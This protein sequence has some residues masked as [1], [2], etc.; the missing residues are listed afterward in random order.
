MNIPPGRPVRWAPLG[1]GFLCL[2][3]FGVYLATALRT[4]VAVGLW[5]DDAIY[6]ATARS[7]AEGD[8]YRHIQMPSRP[9]QTRYPMLYPAMLSLAFL[10]NPEYP[11]NLPLL[12]APGAVAAAGLLLLS[13]YYWRRVFAAPTTLCWLAGGLAAIS[14]VV[15]AFVRYTMSDLVYALL[16]IAALV[17]LDAAAPRARTRGREL[18]WL[19]LGASLV[20][21]AVLTRSIGVTLAA[22]AVLTPLLRRRFADAGVVLGVLVIVAGPW[23]L[24]QAWAAAQNGSLQTA[25]LEAPEL[26]Y[27]L[28]APQGIEPTL[29]VIQ[30]N[31]F[32]AIYSLSFYHLAL[33]IEPVQRALSELS[34]RTGLVH[35]GCYLTLAVTGI[36]FWGSLRRGWRNLHTYALVYAALVIAWPFEPHRFLVPWTPFLLY[37]LLAGFG[38]CAT[39]LARLAVRVRPAAVR[40]PP[41]LVRG[42]LLGLALSL[43]V[44]FAI[45]D[46]RI[47][48]SRADRFYLR[49]LPGGLDLTEAGELYRWLRLRTAPDAVVA[50]AWSAGLF[51]NTERRSYFPW[52]DSDPYLRYYGR[53]RELRDFYGSRSASETQAI[54]RE[55]QAG[56]VETYDRAGIDYCVDQPHWLET[57]VLSHI[58]EGNPRLFELA[59]QSSKKSFRVYRLRGPGR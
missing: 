38:E 4:P 35:G 58:M 11:D 22:A 30:Q 18:A 3:L 46:A 49:E 9:L 52:P 36:G 16:A 14:P 26:S 33:P 53:D 23:W 5:Q 27:G 39:A 45:E 12:L 57:R 51:L 42:G 48:G 37:F 59:F 17:C 43:A 32:R 10:A 29:R 15:L 44:L 50:S 2:C 34:W 8:G 56:L 21:L 24:W 7:L 19:G 20:S 1:L 54:Y 55:M 13:L 31:F 47:L 41:R 25:L 6:V 28:W 40:T